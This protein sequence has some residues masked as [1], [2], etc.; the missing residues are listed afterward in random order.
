[1][2]LSKVLPVPLFLGDIND[3]SS[4]RTQSALMEIKVEEYLLTTLCRICS[5]RI[6][7]PQ[8]LVASKS[9]HYVQTFISHLAFQVFPSEKTGLPQ[10]TPLE[11]EAEMLLSG[12]CTKKRQTESKQATRELNQ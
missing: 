12:M 2:R 6:L 7:S 4:L 5:I 3:Y 9:I 10:T 11:L 1:M 8:D